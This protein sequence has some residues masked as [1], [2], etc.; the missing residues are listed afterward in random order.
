MWKSFK[1]LSFLKKFILIVFIIGVFGAVTGPKAPSKEEAIK[2]WN[3]LTFDEQWVKEI[4]ALK[5]SR[6]GSSGMTLSPDYAHIKQRLRDPD[7]FQF[8][9]QGVTSDKKKKT[10]RVTVVYRAKNGFGGYVEG[11]VYCDYKW[12]STTNRLR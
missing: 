9:A 6:C 11:S 7:S 5:Y 1:E 4:D 3:L 8:I 10:A 2:E 12:D